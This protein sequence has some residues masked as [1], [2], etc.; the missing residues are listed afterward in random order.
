[1]IKKYKIVDDFFF[2]VFIP[3]LSFAFELS[4]SATMLNP[5]FI[6][7]LKENVSTEIKIVQEKKRMNAFIRKHVTKTAT[8]DLFV[9]ERC[10][11]PSHSHCKML[12]TA[13]SF[14]FSINVFPSCQKNVEK[15]STPQSAQAAL[16]AYTIL[17]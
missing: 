12:K 17:G 6:K 1:M 11:F 15:L 8:S 16:D 14:A 9:N 7:Y 10:F 13:M 4:A 3:F 5:R 2:S